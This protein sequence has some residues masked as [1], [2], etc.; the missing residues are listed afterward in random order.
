MPK[1]NLEDELLTYDDVLLEPCYSDV[2]PSAPILKTNLTQKIVLGLPI[3]SSPMDKVTEKEMCIAMAQNGG[4]GILHRNYSPEE[5]VKVVK[6]IKRHEGYIIKR[7][8][9]VKPDMT[10]GDVR[11][12]IKEHRLEFDTFPVVDEKKKIIGILTLTDYYLEK[13]DMTVAKRMSKCLDTITPI[14]SENREIVREQLRK[15]KKKRLIISNKNGKLAGLI[16]GKDFIL[17]DLYPDATRDSQ[18]RLMVGAAV[19]VGK[20][21]VT[22]AGMLY[23]AGVDVVL[24]DI[25]H[26]H[27]KNEIDTI[28]AIKHDCPD[29][30]IIAGNVATEKGVEDLVAAGADCVRIGFGAGSICTTRIITGSGVPQFAAVVRCAEKVRQINEKEGRNI[31]AIADGGIKQYGHMGI[32]LAYADTVMLGNLLAGVDESPGRKVLKDG[33]LYKEYRGMGSMAA[34]SERAGGGKSRYELKNSDTIIPQGVEGVVDYRGPLKNVLYQM[35]GAI[36]FSLATTGAKNLKEFRQKAVINRISK[37]GSEENHPSVNMTEQPVNY[38][39][40]N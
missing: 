5:Q 19:G 31:C 30:Q 33:R 11:D 22:R 13:D 32:A 20:S 39:G 12:L 27:C 8:I 4:I 26:G 17:R 15:K 10:I 1:L 40:R 38:T 14:D 29:L 16:T 3:V 25:S 6:E 36:K 35:I 23:K 24:V 2:E 18:G 21:E 7:P 34:I 28:K 37:S 9:T